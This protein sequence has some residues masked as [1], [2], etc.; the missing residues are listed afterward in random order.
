MRCKAEK[1]QQIEEK[2]LAEEVAVGMDRG[3]RQDLQV[4]PTR[5]WKRG[6]KDWSTLT[7]G[8]RALCLQVKAKCE[9]VGAMW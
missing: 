2:E 5:S 1:E 3:C 4:V 7:T 8:V 6:G 9:H